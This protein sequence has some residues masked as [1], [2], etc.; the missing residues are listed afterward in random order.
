MDKLTSDQKPLYNGEKMVDL[1]QLQI[2]NPITHTK[3]E[4][5]AAQ[6]LIYTIQRAVEAIG[7]LKET[8]KEWQEKRSAGKD[9]SITQMHSRILADAI[10]VYVATLFDGSG[11][12]HSLLNSYAPH[13][14]VKDFSKLPIVKECK[15]NRHNRSAH[16]SRSYGF[17]VQ[18][19]D[20][21]ESPLEAWLKEAVY[22]LAIVAKEKSK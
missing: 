9:G 5:P 16:E 6:A 7:W 10:S 17:F 21:L 14:F 4:V 1:P 19:K 18:A 13:D 12:G 11:R 20:I 8:Q 22:F 15:L 3:K 2:M